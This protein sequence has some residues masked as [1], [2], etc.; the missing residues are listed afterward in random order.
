MRVNMEPPTPREVSSTSSEHALCVR[1]L[2]V[3]QMKNRDGLRVDFLWVWEQAQKEK[4]VG[5]EN[6]QLS[7]SLCSFVLELSRGV[8]GLG[9]ESEGGKVTSPVG[10]KEHFGGESRL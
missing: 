9:T 7:L 6:R 4:K 3:K 1:K 10:D 2:Y 8:W 5:V